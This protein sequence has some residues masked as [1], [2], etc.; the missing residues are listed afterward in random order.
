MRSLFGWISHHLHEQ[1]KPEHEEKELEQAASVDIDV[2]EEACLSKALLEDVYQ[3]DLAKGIQSKM[4]QAPH[5]EVMDPS[6]D[7]SFG[8]VA[9]GKKK[10]KP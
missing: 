8:F 6:K 10:I 7:Y 5:E 2:E 4:L 3:E 9:P 1:L